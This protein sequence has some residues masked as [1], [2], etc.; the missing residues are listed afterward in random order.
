[1]AKGSLTLGLLTIKLLPLIIIITTIDSPSPTTTG[2][3]AINKGDL[4][5][6]KSD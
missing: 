5:Q 6:I 4:E 2:T 1:M 3:H